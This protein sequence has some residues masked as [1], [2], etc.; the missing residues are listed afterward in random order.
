MTQTAYAFW[1]YDLCDNYLE[2]IKPV[3]GN[4]SEENA[5]VCAVFTYKSAC[6]CL[7]P[8]F[9]FAELRVKIGNP[10]SFCCMSLRDFGG[11]CR[12]A[13]GVGTIIG[14]GEGEG[15]WFSGATL[16]PDSH[17]G[18]AVPSFPMQGCC[19]REG[20][21]VSR[22][23]WQSEMM[24]MFAL[25]RKPPLRRRTCHLFACNRYF[26]FVP[27]PPTSRAQSWMVHRR[28]QQL[29]RVYTCVWTTD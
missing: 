11:G 16:L 25:R 24:P 3:V 2:L 29:K 21:S 8:S 15:S 23:N 1:L 12:R 20:C 10:V 6:A 18:H 22:R 19:S 5:K 27:A 13:G 17:P 28:E 14:Q 7:M 4:T 26:C 9:S